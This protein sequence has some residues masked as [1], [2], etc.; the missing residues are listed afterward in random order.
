MIITCNESTTLVDVLSS[1][2]IPKSLQ[3]VC[4]TFLELIK[5]ASSH[6]V[7]AA[8]EYNQHKIN[9]LLIQLLT[10]NFISQNQK[11][12]ENEVNLNI[13][14]LAS[15][16]QSPMPPAM[17]LEEYCER[18]LLNLS[19]MVGFSRK[20]YFMAYK[21]SND[22]QMEIISYLKPIEIFKNIRL[23]S[24]KL[25]KNVE[26]MHQSSKYGYVFC[27]K[28][29]R[30]ESF[31]KTKKYCD[32]SDNDNINIDWELTSGQ[33]LYGQATGMDTYTMEI[34]VSAVMGS[35]VFRGKARYSNAAPAGTMTCRPGDRHK[36]SNILKHGY[37]SKTCDVNLKNFN[38]WT[39]DGRYVNVISGCNK[40]SNDV[41]GLIL[42]GHGGMQLVGVKI[43]L[44]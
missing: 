39:E 29:Y 42:I 40:I 8:V 33:W 27:S 21:I 3:Q 22:I 37:C 12:I 35:Q 19:P 41:V 9:T 2:L 1:T 14:Q 4:S 25:N 13:V 15:R 6:Q 5:N 32:R 38:V 23:T 26:M 16:S 17:D 7:S 31:S 10:I 18:K 28:H 36:F 34:H 43:C 20:N 30:F 44:V 24:R 11:Q